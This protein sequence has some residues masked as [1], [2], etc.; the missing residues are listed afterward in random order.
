M[1]PLTR[2]MLALLCLGSAAL[3]GQTPAPAPLTAPASRQLKAQ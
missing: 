2:S 1:M 3:P